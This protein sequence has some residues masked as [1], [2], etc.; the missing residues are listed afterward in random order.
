MMGVYSLM[1]PSKKN[2]GG[3]FAGLLIYQLFKIKVI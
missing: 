2:I 1:E 3:I